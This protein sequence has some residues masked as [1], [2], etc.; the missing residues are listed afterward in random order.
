MNTSSTSILSQPNARTRL[1]KAAR[2]Y[3]LNRYAVLLV[4]MLPAVGIIIA[5]VLITMVITTNRTQI[6]GV[7]TI[8][9]TQYIIFCV[10]IYRKTKLIKDAFFDISIHIVKSICLVNKLC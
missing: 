7:I 8:L 5:L 4:I 1:F 2:A 6:V 10:F 9:F 3:N